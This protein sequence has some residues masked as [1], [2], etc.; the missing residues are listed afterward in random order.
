MQ[1]Q[2]LKVPGSFF[3]N[4]ISLLRLYICLSLLLLQPS[5][6]RWTLVQPQGRK[7]LPRWSFNI[8]V[9]S[10]ITGS[11]LLLY[12]GWGIIGCHSAIVFL[13]SWS[14]F[15]SS[16]LRIAFC[17][18]LSLFLTLRVVLCEGLIWRDESTSSCLD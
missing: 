15:F 8:N 11:G 10:G 1:N 4:C 2:K 9:K 16:L 12:F 7:N 17:W 5:V 3:N 6:F 14:Y 18:F 13:Y